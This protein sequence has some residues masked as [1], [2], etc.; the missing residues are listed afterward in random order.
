MKI[1]SMFKLAGQ[2]ITVVQ[3]SELY[4]NRKILGEAVYSKSQLLLDTGA[5]SQD[6]MEQNFIHELLHW[7]FF[8]MNENE[9]RSNEKLVDLTAHMLHQFV[10]TQTFDSVQDNAIQISE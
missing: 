6:Q 8:I 10:K 1:P 2:T 7:V 3:D 4:A 9:L 5:C